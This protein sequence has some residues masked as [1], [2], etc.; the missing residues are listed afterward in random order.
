M[1]VS[2]AGWQLLFGSLTIRLTIERVV[3]A[4]RNVHAMLWRIML[5]GFL[6]LV[7]WPADPSR[8]QYI[9]LDANGDGACS[10]ADRL[11]ATQPTAVDI[12]LQTDANRDGSRPICASRSAVPLSIFSYEFILHAGG[13][14]VEW[15][16]YTN[17]QPTMDFKFGEL[18]SKTDFYTGYGGGPVLPPGKYRLGTLVVRVASGAP[19]LQFASRA[20][21]WHWVQTSFGSMNPGKD[22]FNTLRY[23]EDP[24]KLGSPI[25]DVAGDWGDADGIAAGGIA[26]ASAEVPPLRFEVSV[27]PN[28]VNPV[29]II[30]V[31]T[32]R[33]GFLSVRLFDVQGRLVRVLMDRRDAAAG[34]YPLLLSAGASNG[35]LA[36]GV[37]FYSVEAGEGH[38]DGRVVVLK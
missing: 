9:W 15:G 31:S 19:K 8:A 11:S 5:M 34:R 33:P 18:R 3:R 16:T 32:T 10:L 35:T 14:T 25:S 12:W 27:A 7:L 1:S 26:F 28:P 30:T 17:L 23:T 38:L 29:A 20:P 36:S 2:P 4:G 13:G 37:Y 24:T 6:F 21:L 22:G